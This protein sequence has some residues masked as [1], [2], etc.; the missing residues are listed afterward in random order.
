MSIYAWYE[1]SNR[2]KVRSIEVT[3]SQYLIACSEN[4]SKHTSSSRILLT[5]LG[6]TAQEDINAEI[7][8]D[9]L[10]SLLKGG[11]QERMSAN[12]AEKGYKKEG[13]KF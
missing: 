8:A 2:Y 5:L 7:E 1:S 10:E 6:D 9:L 13:C 12:H 3:I 4:K 11:Y